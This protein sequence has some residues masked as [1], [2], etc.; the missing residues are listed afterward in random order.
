M[1]KKL[2]FLIGYRAVGK[3]TVGKKL[4]HRLGYTFVDSDALICELKHGSVD[5]IVKAEGWE[6]FRR[7]EQDVLQALGLRRQSV[8]ATGGG[9]ILHQHLWPGLKEHGLVVWLTAAPDV[10]CE[11]ILADRVSQSQRPSLTGKGLCEEVLEVL[12]EREP[13]YRKNADLIVDTGKLSVEE[14]VDVIVGQA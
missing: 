9:A 7:A 8:I 6:G 10:I 14:V 13:L 11:R 12:R 4:A 3:T 2:I 1:L 5:E